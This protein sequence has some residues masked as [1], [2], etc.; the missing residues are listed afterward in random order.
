MDQCAE[1]GF[2]YDLTIA[3]QA[4]QQISDG[5]ARLAELITT[6]GIGDLPRPSPDVWSPLEYACHVRDVLLVQRERVLLARRTQ[7]PRLENMGRDERVEHEGYAE[8]RG[9]DVARQLQDAAL[10]F[11]NVLSRLG[12]D[13]WDRTVIYGFPNSAERS[14]RWVAVHTLHEV[15]H[16]ILDVERQASN[17]Q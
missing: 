9:S 3:T 1:C 17:G 14:L 11:T 8:Q 2:S 4:G 12:D 7:C 15:R 16:H 6:P 5:V 13:D 10:L